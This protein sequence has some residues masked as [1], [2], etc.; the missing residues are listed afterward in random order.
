R[1]SPPASPAWRQTRRFRP[2]DGIGGTR[3]STCHIR[4][5]ADATARPSAPSTSCLRRTAGCR[6]PVGSP[7]RAPAV[8][9]VRSVPTP[10]PTGR[11]A[12]PMPPPNGSVESTKREA[13]EAEVRGSGFV[14]AG[15]DASP[16]LELAEEL[17]DPAAQ[18]ILP[19][20]VQGGMVSPP[21]GGDHRLDAMKGDLG[22]DCVGVV[23][24]VGQQRFHLAGDHAEQGTEA[25]HVMRLARC[26]HEA[27]WTSFAIA[28][29]VELGGEAAARAAERLS[30]PSPFFMPT[31][32]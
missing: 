20:V 17:L 15:G 12:L 13:D 21:L 22:P 32:Q 16:V 30:R 29:G 10:H 1:P 26:Q 9:A 23:T 19:S 6:P 28:S 4:P 3:C 31:A 7:A 5:A 8:A 27:K 11:S 25:L 2:S 24:A 18:A 14:I